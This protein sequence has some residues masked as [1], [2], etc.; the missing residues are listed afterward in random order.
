MAGLLFISLLLITYL[1]GTV[2][3]HHM[4]TRARAHIDT[5]DLCSTQR[6]LGVF[7][8]P[9][10]FVT[11]ASDWSLVVYTHQSEQAR[12]S[13]VKQKNK[14]KTKTQNQQWFA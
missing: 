14:N 7:S 6:A 12:L 13:S 10:H 1:R 9:P 8:P 5:S 11:T 2:K 3:P 4:H